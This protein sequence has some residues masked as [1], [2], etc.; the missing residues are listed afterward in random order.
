V[1]LGELQ[2]GRYVI[3]TVDGVVLVDANANLQIGDQLL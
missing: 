1:V 3:S 2:D